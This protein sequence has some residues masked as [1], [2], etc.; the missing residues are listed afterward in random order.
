MDAVQAIVALHHLERIVFRRILDMGTDVQLSKRIVSF[1]LWLEAEGYEDIV[2]RLCCHDDEL[3][4]HACAEAKVALASLNSDSLQSGSLGVIPITA[5]LSGCRSSLFNISKNKDSVSKDI[6][7]L[8]NGVCSVIFKDILEEKGLKADNNNTCDESHD[9]KTTGQVVRKWFRPMGQGMNQQGGAAGLPGLSPINGTLLT[10]ARSKLNPFAKE[11]N[12]WQE[13]APE[14]DRSLFITFSNGYPLSNFQLW[15]FFTTM[16]GDCVE[17]VD[18][19][20]AETRRGPP[21]FGRVVFTKSS[22]PALIVNNKEHAKF[23]VHGRPLW[24]KKYQPKKEVST[25]HSEQN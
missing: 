22:V 13:R 7:G 14:E 21:L 23:L 1:W 5:R 18:V 17:K 12:P 19:N 3:L 2:K 9:I 6:S 15:Q 25:S 20:W 4:A 8:C 11:W 24:C 10:R 16:Y